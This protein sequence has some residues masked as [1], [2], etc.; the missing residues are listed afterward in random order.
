MDTPTLVAVALVAAV[1]GA[2]LG[3][4]ARSMWASQ[5][6]KAAKAA[7]QAERAAAKAARGNH[8]NH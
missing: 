6:M 7:R 2:V 5:G 8:K 1:G 3:A 4:L